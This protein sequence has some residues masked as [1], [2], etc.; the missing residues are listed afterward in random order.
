LQ[1]LHRKLKA[2]QKQRKQQDSALYGKMFKALGKGSSHD[3]TA[4]A[5]AA[6]NGEAEQGMNGD[7]EA[8]EGKDQGAAAAV[9]TEDGMGGTTDMVTAAAEVPDVSGTAAPMTVDAA[10]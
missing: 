5:A 4:G 6:G 7:V 10:A 8:G 1:A 3:K 9:I 2:A